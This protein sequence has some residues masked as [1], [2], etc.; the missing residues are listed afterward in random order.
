MEN[1]KERREG[2]SKNRI[3]CRNSVANVRF[4]KTEDDSPRSTA[5]S[6]EE[7]GQFSDEN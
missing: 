2:I 4:T 6:A 1:R 3:K 5:T 7:M